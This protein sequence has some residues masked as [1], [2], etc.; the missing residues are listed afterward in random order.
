[1][2]FI[3]AICALVILSLFFFAF[4]QIF[5]PAYTAWENAMDEYEK[6]K[7]I[8]FVSELFLKECEKS[9]RDIEDW[10]KAVAVSKELESYE[11]IELKD[12]DVL[13]ALKLV[14]I[15]G[16]ESIEVIGLCAP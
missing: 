7:T 14:C 11:V 13:R 5:L 1:M 10:K 6:A 8:H 3:D 12:A 16:G 4:A 15:I 9:R 2:T